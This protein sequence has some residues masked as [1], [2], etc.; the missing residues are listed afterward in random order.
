VSESFPRRSPFGRIGIPTAMNP[1]RSS[2]RSLARR[3]LLLP[4]LLLLLGLVVGGVHDH[5][6]EDGSH[7]CAICTLSH[8]PAT[9]T[10]AQVQPAPTMHAERVVASSPGVLRFAGPASPSSRAPPSI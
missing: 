7:A 8:A 5:A 6:R 3:M 9:A 2:P 10:V 1:S 4:G